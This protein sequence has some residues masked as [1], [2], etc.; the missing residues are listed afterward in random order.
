MGS[1]FDMI[2]T[3]KIKTVTW[4]IGGAKLLQEDADQTLL[5]SY[6]VEGIDQIIDWLRK[7]S[8]DIIT[9]QE[10]QKNDSNDQVATLAQKLGYEYFYHDSTSKS[11]IDTDYNL[12]HAILS[13]YP[14][15]DHTMG[16]FDNPNL[17]IAWEDGSIA[18]SF[19]KGYSTCR[20]SIDGTD[21]S[22]TTLHL[23]PFKRFGVEMGTE[24]AATILDNV[25]ESL[26][27]PTDKWIIQ[28]DFNIDSSLLASYLPKLFDQGLSEIDITEP[29]TPKGRRYD[30]ILFRHVGLLNSRTDSNVLTDHFP[31]IAEFEV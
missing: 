24:A 19:D 2:N 14:L 21:I 1:T 22:L 26:S 31:V 9:L 7:E 11:H 17:K 25:A 30:H 8:P 20:A 23:V 10:T 29:T 28:G 16:F 5:A 13:R 18:Q 6:S 4:N 27:A 15:S 12:G 3:M